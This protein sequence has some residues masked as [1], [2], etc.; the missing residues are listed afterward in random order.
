MQNLSDQLGRKNSS[1]TYMIVQR[2]FSTTEETLGVLQE[3]M[4]ISVT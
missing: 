3:T 4:Q 1:F 2:N